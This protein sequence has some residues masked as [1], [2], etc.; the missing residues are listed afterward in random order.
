MPI[1]TK[2]ENASNVIIYVEIIHIGESLKEFEFKLLSRFSDDT[3][4]ERE[5]FREP[6]A[7]KEEEIWVYKANSV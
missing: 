2:C 7:L 4:E 5:R 1:K 3:L 6:N